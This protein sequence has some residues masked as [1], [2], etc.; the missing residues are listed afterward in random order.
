M[1]EGFDDSEIGEYILK[2]Y[3]EKKKKPLKRCCALT[4]FSRLCRNRASNDSDYCE[5]HNEQIKILDMTDTTDDIDSMVEEDLGVKGVK[6]TMF[7]ID[8]STEKYLIQKE[9]FEIVEEEPNVFDY[10]NRM[11]LKQSSTKSFIGCSKRGAGAETTSCLYDSD[12][13]DDNEEKQKF[14]LHMEFTKV[15]G[16]GVGSVYWA[17]DD[18]EKG[19]LKP[20]FFPIVKNCH[21]SYKDTDLDAIHFKKIKKMMKNVETN[22]MD[23]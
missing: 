8:D 23:A 14:K 1:S 7:Q 9:T 12:S 6:K 3:L 5:V 17:A 22:Y 21:P 16:A 15:Y 11:E 19:M 20:K 2:T 4:K 18:F 10:I 13:D